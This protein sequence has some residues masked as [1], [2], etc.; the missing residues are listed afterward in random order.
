MF[1]LCYFG[2]GFSSNLVVYLTGFA[3]QMSS[4]GETKNIVDTG[5]QIASFSVLL[6]SNTVPFLLATGIPCV[7]ELALAKD[8]SFPKYGLVL[9]LGSLLYTVSLILGNF[10]SHSMHRHLK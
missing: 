8:L 4:L 7:S 1:S 3:D 5:S 9:I 2:I 10:S 6:A